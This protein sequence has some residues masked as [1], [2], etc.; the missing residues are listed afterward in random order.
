MVDFDQPRGQISVAGLSMVAA[1]GILIWSAIYNPP[2][3]PLGALKGFL[4]AG[5]AQVGLSD[6]TST[7]VN[8]DTAAKEAGGSSRISTGYGARVVA[9]ART[10]LGDPY[11]WAGASHDGIDCS[12]LV[13]VAYRDGAGISLPH[14][15]TGQAAKGKRINADEVVAGD[16]VCWGVPGNFPHIALAENRDT[17]IAAWTQ[18]VG[19]QEGPIHQKAVAGFGYPYFY[20]IFS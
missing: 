18:G 19:V 12:G 2:Q 5:Q 4:T 11:V 20:R 13:M 6:N 9:V 1:G 7:A 8:P 3:G 16:L 15:A 10:Y 14:W 17:C